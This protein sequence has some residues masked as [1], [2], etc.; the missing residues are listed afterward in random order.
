MKDRQLMSV[1]FAD[2]AEFREQLLAETLRCVR[3]KRRLRHAGQAL[4]TVM[5]AAL[6]LWWTLPRR[7]PFEIAP[8]A[9]GVQIVRSIPLSTE[10]LITTRSDSVMIISSDPSSVA[11]LG[12]DQ[13]LDLAPGETKLLVWHG[14]HKA[15]LVIV[16]P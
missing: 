11:L 3:R 10:Q 9:G 14:P 4:L 13:L 12:D 16:G 8:Q 15:E 6:A 7:A 1:M 2:A 5:I